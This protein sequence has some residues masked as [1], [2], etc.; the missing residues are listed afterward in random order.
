VTVWS[1]VKDADATRSV[2]AAVSPPAAVSAFPHRRAGHCG[3]GALRDLLEHRGL[4]FGAGP[5]SE[6]AVFGLSGALGFFYVELPEMRPPVYLVGRTADLETDI[7]AHLGVGLDVRETDDPGEGWS[8]VAEEVDA[9]RPPVVWADIKHLD[10]LR[11]RMH[12]TRH[13]IVVVGYDEDE[14]V[15]W[16]AD[17]DRDDLQP[18]SLESLA[19][20]RDS[21]AF[22]GPNRHRV[23]VYDW[24]QRLRDPRAAT[25]DAVSRAVRTMRGDT[26]GEFAGA[27][28]NAGLAGVEA[29]AA[30][31]PRWPETFGADL[32]AALS[33][34]RVLIVK[35]GTGGAMFRSLQ[36]GFLREL[37][38]LLNDDGLTAAAEAYDELTRAWQALAG[39]AEARDHAAGCAI[40]EDLVALEREGVERMEAWLE[41]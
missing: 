19:R 8:L 37:G 23:F 34:L 9:G 16:I 41:R 4:D 32:D 30:A 20:A 5:L 2:R 25:R 3:S 1:H 39:A 18:C 11:V 35:A 38:D 10:Y 26:S 33:G 40:T 13:D 28:P 12:N 15:A 24:P 36:A 6:G 14:G 21:P 7:A 17:N 27:V 29:F 31:Y 22:P